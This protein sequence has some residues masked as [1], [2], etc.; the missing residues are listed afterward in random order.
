MTFATSEAFSVKPLSV[1][2]EVIGL[3]L[4]FPMDEDTR[5]Q[6]YAAWLE[7]GILVFRNVGSI[8]VHIALSRCFGEL[9]IHPFP[10]ARA[11]ENPLFIEIGGEKQM[12]AFL[13]DESELRVNRIPWH[14]DTA[15][16]PGICKGAMLRMLE[17]PPV[18]GE[19]LFA[20]T[21]IAYDE[22]PEQV[23]R[24]LQGLEYKA[25]LRL[26][27]INQTRPGALWQT[28]R[29][30]TAAEDPGGAGKQV[31]DNEA[32]ARYPAVIQPAVLTHPESGRKCIFLSPTYVDYFLGISE[33]ESDALL[34]YLVEHTTQARYVYQHKWCIDDAILWDNRRF[35]HA[36]VGNNVGDRRRGLRTTLA[37]QLN[38]GRYFNDT[39]ATPRASALVD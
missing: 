9:E 13:Y 21:A 25:S 6:L 23:K 2:A 15:Y 3:K 26:G 24:R 7:Y 28:A 37:G 10:E 20:D 30:A 12:P 34:R 14:R 38:T 32:E 11:K 39:A 19:T 36:A 22:L 8:D 5:R 4:E 33:Q 17:V 35:M 16:T 18:H 31:Y 1:G 29:A 27:I